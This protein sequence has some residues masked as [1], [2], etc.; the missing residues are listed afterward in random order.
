MAS[1]SRTQPATHAPGQSSSRAA[2]TPRDSLSASQ[3]RRVALRA[4]GLDRG[5]PDLSGPVTM[6][7]FQQVVDRVGLLQIDSVNVLARAHLMPVYSRLGPYD[8]ALLDRASGRAP[9]RL[10]ETWAHEAS[11]VPPET[12]RMLGW[13]RRAYRT[14]AWGTIRDVPL[15]H[16]AEV[17]EIRRLVAAHGPVT[18]SQVHAHFEAEHPRTRTE[19]GWNWTVAKRV[20]EYLFFTGEVAAARRNAQFER[21]YDLVERVLPAEVLARPEPS[22]D[23]ALRGLVEIGARAHGVGSARCLLDYFRLRGPAPSRALDELVEDGVLLPVRVEAGGG[24]STCTATRLCHA[25]RRP[26]R[27]SARSTPSSSRGGGS[28]SSSV[29]AT[30]S[31]S[32][33]PST[34]A[35]TA[36]TCCRS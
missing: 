12:Y 19:W 18:A 13:R 11:F 5:R 9:R 30:A 26:R 6:R 27:C 17:A 33:C 10:V 23:E 7:Q 36:T 29:C 2:P 31:R 1:T 34:S 14:S 8:T 21:C 15:A 22:D 16:A 20:L 3:A 35:C 28:R 4:Q 32:T 25:R 24:P